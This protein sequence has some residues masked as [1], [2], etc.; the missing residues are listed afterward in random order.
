MTSININLGDAFLI[1][2][3]PNDKHLY[4]AIAPIPNNKYLFVN[5]TT[6]RAR[7]EIACILTPSMAGVPS[8]ITSESVIAYQFAREMDS[9]LLARDI[10]QGSRTPY[11]QFPANI[12]SK[13]QQGGLVSRRLENR[14]QDA[15]RSFL[16]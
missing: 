3:P 2:T 9:T 15:L 1:E 10:C 16:G 6:R 8:F 13:I 11:C 12:L 7:S 14:Y 4:I 5:L